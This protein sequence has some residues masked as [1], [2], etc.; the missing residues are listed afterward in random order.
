MINLRLALIACNQF[1]FIVLL[2]ENP[3]TNEQSNHLR[4]ALTHNK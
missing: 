4:T 3:G 1:T 2:Q